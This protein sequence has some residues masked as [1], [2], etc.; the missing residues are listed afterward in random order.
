MRDNKTEL[1]SLESTDFSGENFKHFNF[2]W[3]KGLSN[4]LS[5]W[6]VVL[7]SVVLV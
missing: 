5:S 6:S 2:K 3:V 1:S 4:Y 7:P